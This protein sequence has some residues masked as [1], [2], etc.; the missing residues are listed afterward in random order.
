MVCVVCVLSVCIQVYMHTE[1]YYVT[2]FS[3]EDKHTSI[4]PRKEESKYR[5]MYEYTK[6]QV[7]KPVSSIGVIY[8][9]MGVGL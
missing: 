8:R 1:R 6:V 3:W 4:H 7:G 5:A 2:N 9:N